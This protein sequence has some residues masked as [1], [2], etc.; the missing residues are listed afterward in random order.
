MELSGIYKIICR[1]NNKFYIGSSININRRFKD[2]I[3]LLKRNNNKN[4]YLQNSWNKYG[5][6]NF[7]FE[8]IEIVN[9]VKQLLIREKWWIDNTNC[10]NRKIGFNISVDPAAPQ[11]GNFNDLTG[12]KFGKLTVVKPNGKNQWGNYR[13]LCRCYCGKEKIISS[14]NL[15]SGNTKSCGCLYVGGNNFKHGK[16]KIGKVSKFIKYGAI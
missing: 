13:W 11:T 16:T 9:N 6:K 14:T 12:Q 15:I 4:K 10:Y 1:S 2:H 3:R 8:I 7:K 5:E